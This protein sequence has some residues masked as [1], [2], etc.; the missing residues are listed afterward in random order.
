MNFFENLSQTVAKFPGRIVFLKLS[1]VA[2]PPDVVAD[3]V[4]LFI[5]PG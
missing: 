1:H 4:R 3:R 2:D 5:A